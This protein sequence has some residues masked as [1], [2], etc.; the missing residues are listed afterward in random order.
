MRLQDQVEVWSC[1]CKLYARDI[2]PR[3]EEG[4]VRSDVNSWEGG[5]D[6]VVGGVVV[7]VEVSHGVRRPM[8]CSKLAGLRRIESTT[9]PSKSRAE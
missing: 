4:G 6:M 2:R 1:K 5:Y 7:V 9:L 8:T 3:R